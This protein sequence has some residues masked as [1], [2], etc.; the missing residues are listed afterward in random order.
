M[1]GWRYYGTWADRTGPTGAL[2]DAVP[3]AD[4]GA[5]PRPV[6]ADLRDRRWCPGDQRFPGH[7]GPRE[8]FGPGGVT[9]DGMADV[10]GDRRHREHGADRRI[11]AAVNTARG[12]RGHRTGL[13][14]TSFHR[15]RAAAVFYP[16]FYPKKR[17]S[18]VEM[19]YHL[20]KGTNWSSRP[21]CASSF[22]S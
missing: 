17:R 1:P 7:V 9:A 20:V 22:P 11:I 10:D 3:G 14:C 12:I 13:R 18:G 16:V 15:F 5:R 2:T 21:E 4:A 6:L 8:L 19:V